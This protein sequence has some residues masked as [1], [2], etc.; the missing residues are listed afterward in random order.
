MSETKRAE[1]V[2][3]HVVEGVVSFDEYGAIQSVNPAAE[4]IFGY[5]ASELIGRSIKV[6]FPENDGDLNFPLN[7][8]KED[9]RVIRDLRGRRKGGSV[10]HLD[11]SISNVDFGGSPIFIGI[12]RDIS[13]RKKSE[14][15]LGLASMIYENIS[16]ATVVTDADNNIVSVNP[17]F[18]DIT[19]YSPEEVIGKNPGIMK[20]GRHDKEFYREMWAS[21]IGTGHW[22]GEIWDRRRN[23]GIYPKWL[24]ISTIRDK[25]N[26]KVHNYI[27]VFTDITERKEAEKRIQFMA[28]YDALTGLPNRV[29]LQDRLA[30]ELNHASR[31]NKQVAL[32]FFDL[33]RFKNINDTLG[34]NVG[35]LLLQS[36]AG[37]LKGCLRSVDTVARLGGDEFV[38][39]LPDLEEAEYAGTVARKLLES[40]AT[41]HQLGEH[42]LTTTASVG[43]SVY[44]QDGG[45]RETLVKNAD[46]AMYKSKEAGRNNYMFF[47]EE[48][49]ARA[50]ERLSMENSLRKALERE[51]FTLYFQPQVN[52]VTGRIIGAEALI[53]WRH[54]AMG[55]VMPAK[56][57]PIAEESGMIVAIGEWVLRTACMKNRQWQKAGLQTVP[58][59]VNLSAL[60]FMQKDLVEIVSDT[61]LQTGLEP[62]RLELEITESSIIQN[63]EAAINTLKELKAMGVSLSIDDFGTGYSNLGYLKKFPID[64]LK[65]DQSFVRDIVNDPDDAAIV[66]AIINLA[67]SLQLRV[68]AEGVETKEQLDFLS[69]HGCDEVQGYY[70]SRP[71]PE[72]EF[73]AML[74]SDRAGRAD[75]SDGAAVALVH[76]GNYH[77]STQ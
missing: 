23:G 14:M 63:A 64:K 66:R 21:I 16:E 42:E 33:D 40:L 20:S 32:M 37:R 73:R 31:N 70:F 51:E 65:V 4:K 38:V 13:D 5:P 35:D 56:F 58:V 49:N 10:Y 46:V 26:G 48:M 75:A 47:R 41:P 39:I 74:I 45:D 36:V 1:T 76:G 18:T 17:A 52:T 55:L 71:V 44:P 59:A 53:R 25:Q 9:S 34:H 28:H 19:G 8:R 43:I 67:K 7:I 11:L 60:Q 29:L 12:L 61:V 15:E 24:S 30:H 27:A 77:E 50:G 72:E 6:L 3:Q 57:I 54:P 2:M 69:A 22:Q 62:C 68:M